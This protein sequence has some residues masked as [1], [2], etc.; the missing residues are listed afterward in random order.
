MA[1]H[2]A[3]IWYE[4]MT[5]DPAGARAFYRE[6]VGWDIDAQNSIP[7]ADMDYRMI[8]RSDGGYVGGVMGMSEAQ[9]G[10]M[11]PCWMGYIHHP[12]VGGAVKAI[13]HAG[14]QV[15]MPPMD[16]EGVGRMAMVADPQG[17][18]F[19]VMNPAPPPDQPEAPSDVFDYTKAQHMRW[20]EL[21]TTDQDAAL[22]LYCRLF[23]WSQ[24]GAMPMG[25]MGD[26]K[27]ISREG[28]MIGAIMPKMPDVPRSVWTFYVGVDDID[29]A[30]AAATAAG[31]R[32][33][34]EIQQIPGGDYALHVAD[35]QG[36]QIGLVG[37]RKG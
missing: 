23:G 31:G 32:H 36:A 28:K 13:T 30:A 27:F 8:K 12:D 17:A 21:Q 26:Y 37:P 5:P 2:G 29:R 1:E 19:Y 20:N 10:S 22:E 15:H 25:A 7:G 14:G 9:A 35:P 16:M 3:F 33:L 24:D 4:L 34:G 6:V 11:P 18:L